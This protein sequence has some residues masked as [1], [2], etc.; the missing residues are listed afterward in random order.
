MAASPCPAF[1][2]AFPSPS[3]ASRSPFPSRRPIP[4]PRPLPG[5]ATLSLSRSLAKPRN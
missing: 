2:V 5:Q 1:S 4:F 3:R